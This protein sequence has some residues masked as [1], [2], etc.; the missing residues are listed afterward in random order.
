MALREDI[1]YSEELQALVYMVE[2]QIANTPFI[3]ANHLALVGLGFLIGKLRKM[4]DESPSVHTPT[5]H[6]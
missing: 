5:A 4:A 1:L 2:Q 3:P 6:A